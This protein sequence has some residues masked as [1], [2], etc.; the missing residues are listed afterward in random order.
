MSHRFAIICN[1]VLA[2]VM[3]ICMFISAICQTAVS[4]Q[5]SPACCKQLLCVW[6]QCDCSNEKENK[7]AAEKD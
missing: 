2:L 7:H 4:V 3:S 5:Y 1:V 6:R